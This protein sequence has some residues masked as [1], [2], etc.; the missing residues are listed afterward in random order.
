MKQWLILVFAA[1]AIAGC[2][3][4]EK[5]AAIGAGTG[6]VVGGIATG[7]VQGAAVG[8][9]VGGIAGALIGRVSEGSNR[10]YYRDRYGRRY[11][12]ACPSGY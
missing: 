2:T 8:A 11:V 9:A 10:C 12:D 7:N 5:G 4:T 3:P 1:F 6:A